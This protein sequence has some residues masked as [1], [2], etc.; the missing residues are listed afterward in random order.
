LT[1][2]ATASPI[3]GD[4]NPENNSFQLDQTVVGSFDPNDIQCLE[5]ER[6]SLSQVGDYVH[7][8]IR[9]ENTG[10]FPAENIVVKNIID[11]QKFDVASLSV[12]SGSHDFVTRSNGNEIE[13]IFEEINLPFDDDTNDG[14][15]LYKIKTRSDLME[16][17]FFTNSAEI[18]FDFNFPILTNN[19]TTEIGESLSVPEVT[20]GN[21]MV[22]YPNPATD[23]VTINSRLV[24]EQ[25]RI[26]NVLGAV[27]TDVTPNTNHH[28]LKV[29]SFDSGVYFIEVQSGSKKTLKKFIKN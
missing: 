20:T 1:F 27:I 29:S 2:E 17:D 21:S 6:I 22:F 5:G 8:R 23:T 13:F 11:T 26:F 10:T 4:A 19:Y 18:Y 9:F 14:F 28:V 12:I 3:A 25:V 7:Y 15:I 24:M 16:D